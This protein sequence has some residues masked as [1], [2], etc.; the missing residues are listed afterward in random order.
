ARPPT[1][2][3]IAST[4]I[5]LPAP[6]S[7]VSALKPASSSSEARSISTKSRTSSARS[8][9]FGLDALLAPAEL[10]AQRGE[11]AVARRMDEAHH[12]ERRHGGMQDRALRGERVGGRAGRR[13]EDHAVGA[14]RIDEFAVE[15]KLELDQ[16]PLRALA[17][18]RF[19][20]RDG[21]QHRLR[22]A[23]DF[24]V[25]HRAF[26][27]AV[28]AVEDRADA[29][30][31]VAM[32]DVGHEADAPEV[33]ADHRHAVTHQIACGGEQCAVAADDHRE[34]GGA[35]NGGV[36][37]TRAAGFGSGLL[38]DQRV[39]AAGLEERDELAQRRADLR[40]AE[41]A[42]QRNAAEAR[43]RYGGHRGCEC[44]MNRMLDKRAQIL[45][46]TLIERYIAE[47]QP[48]GSRTLSKFS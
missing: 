13:G 22:A 46:K 2:S 26:F 9:L 39:A 31:H 29:G 7:P 3:S 25:E 5:D 19:V 1:S 34:I 23:Q 42:D 18:H 45:L 44:T 28:L 10:L 20:E 48:V 17:D 32:A 43:F 4:R 21:A 33:H 37:E 11:V 8:M 47:G 6:V 38:F 12:V 15:R 41:L 30:A 14:Q 40:A 35:A 27:D 16:A 24:G 36:V